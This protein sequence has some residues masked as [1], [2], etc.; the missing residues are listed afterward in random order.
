MLKKE[1]YSSG[2]LIIALVIILALM[3]V[4]KQNMGLAKY[5]LPD[6]PGDARAGIVDSC[7]INQLQY[8]QVCA[9]GKNWQMNALP[10]QEFVP[11]EDTTR[12]VSEN[13]VS[14]LVLTLGQTEQPKARIELG[15]IRYD[16][17]YTAERL[18]LQKLGE[19]F[20]EYN[21]KSGAII[22]PQPVTKT[23]YR[24]LPGAFFMV[25]LPKTANEPFP[26]LVYATA[27]RYQYAYVFLCQTT[28][29]F[30][31]VVKDD[32]EKTIKSIRAIRMPM[33]NS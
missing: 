8:L 2:L 26:V 24:S 21:Q 6:L 32:F 9:P 14:L 11:L 16:K 19:I 33:K 17:N 13:T 20:A 12:T 4:M 30:Y 27:I 5:E 3:W 15:V 7:Y 22:L 1:Y 23:V 28:E 18:A 31:P 29:E 10:E 25:V